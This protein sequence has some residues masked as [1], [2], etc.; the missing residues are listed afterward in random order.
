MST[1]KNLNFSFNQKEY[2]N[3]QTYIQNLDGKYWVQQNRD[4]SGERKIH[5]PI[6]HPNLIMSFSL[7]ELYELKDLL[8]AN[9]FPPQKLKLIKPRTVELHISNN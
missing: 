4:H 1:I 2:K 8:V 7:E 3:F 5:I 6:N 9:L